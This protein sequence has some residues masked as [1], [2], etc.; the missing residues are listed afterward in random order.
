MIQE[1]LILTSELTLKSSYRTGGSFDAA[2][3]GNDFQTNFQTTKFGSP[4]DGLVFW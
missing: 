1:Q 3:T 4:F 2:S